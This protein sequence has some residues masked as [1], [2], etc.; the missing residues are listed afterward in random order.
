MHKRW[1]D[2]H[3]WSSAGQ[4]QHYFRLSDA[5]GVASIGTRGQSA[6]PWQRKNCQKS[7]KIREKSG[8]KEKLGKNPEKEEKSGRKGQNREGSFTLPLL[9]NRAGY[10]TV[11][12]MIVLGKRKTK[13]FNAAK[14]NADF[15]MFTSVRTHTKD[16]PSDITLGKLTP[17][18]GWVLKV[19]NSKMIENWG[20]YP[21]IRW[22][23]RKGWKP[24]FPIMLCKQGTDG[25]T[26]ANVF[27][28]FSI[29]DF[30]QYL[31]HACMHH[32][33]LLNL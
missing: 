4:L 2:L 19:V 1:L 14:K 24:T 17:I 28:Y 3:F 10:A 6:P 8:K 23:K 31:I 32:N 12:C 27:T 5:S 22:K 30:V 15:T 9:T 26:D 18:S 29:H 13:I 25:F 21:E 20:S 7:G 11:R 16:K 33:E